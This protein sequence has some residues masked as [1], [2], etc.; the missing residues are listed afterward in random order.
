MKRANP[1]M[2]RGV[3]NI[4]IENPKTN[5]DWLSRWRAYPHHFVE[6]ALGIRK[7]NGLEVSIQQRKALQDLGKMVFAKRKAGHLRKQGQP[8]PEE[9]KYWTSRSGISI[10]SGKGTGKDAFAS[11]AIIWFLS[12]FENARIPCIGPG[13]DQLNK[14]L[15][16]EIGKWIYKTNQDGNYCFI[17][18]FRN[19][20]KKDNKKIYHTEASVPGNEW[21]AFPKTVPNYVDEELVRNILGGQHEE[22]MMLVI[23][24]ATGVPDP[25]IDAV[26]NS[27]TKDNNFGL[28]IFNPNKASGYAYGSHYDEKLS[29]LWHPIHWNAEESDNVSKDHIEKQ[30]IKYGS[31]ENDNYRVYVLGEPPRGEDDSLIPF[32]WV[33]SAVNREVAYKEYPIYIG[34]DVAGGGADSTVYCVRQGSKVHEFQESFKLDTTNRCAEIMALVEKYDASAIMV[35][36]N[37]VG[38]SLAYELKHYFNPVYPVMVTESATSDRFNRLRCELWWRCR[39]RFEKG[40]ISIPPLDKLEEDLKTIKYD[41]FANKGKIVV[42]AKKDLK[43]RLGRSPD[44]ADAMNL[45]FYIDERLGYKPVKKKIDPYRDS[46]YDRRRNS[47]GRTWMSY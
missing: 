14:V 17:D 9:Y 32:E 34:V 12:L 30:L 4:N 8:V 29:Q 1:R 31:K 47:A 15:W 46:S 5:R 18:C 21:F 16:P 27:F 6:E 42:E 28:M 7:E 22:N 45:T 33:Q 19:V 3:R 13:G 26:E 35:D 23:D 40:L 43:R 38:N 24:E 25:V 36:A 20:L 39:E 2:A 37:G 41:A 10:R 44:F 11:W